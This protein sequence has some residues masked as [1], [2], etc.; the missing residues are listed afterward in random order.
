V[1]KPSL[2]ALK[3]MHPTNTNFYTILITIYQSL[4]HPDPVVRVLPPSSSPPTTPKP[5]ENNHKSLP[6][7]AVRDLSR[8]DRL[9]NQRSNPIGNNHASPKP[10]K[11]IRKLPPSTRNTHRNL[12]K[13]YRA[14][15]VPQTPPVMPTSAASPEPANRPSKAGAPAEPSPS[16]AMP[17]VKRSRQSMTL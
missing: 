14:L 3:V 13:N 8:C 1:T 11:N 15:R 6:Q 2:P 9:N 10:S 16:P 12:T 7:N 4:F 17:M 5:L